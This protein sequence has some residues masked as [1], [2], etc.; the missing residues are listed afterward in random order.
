MISPPEECFI[1]D[2]AYVP[3]HLPGYVCAI[4]GAEPHLLGEDY[5]CFRMEDTL[6]F[7]GYPLRGSFAESA[8]GRAIETAVSRFKPRQVALIAPKI[9]EGVAAGQPR[10]RDQCYR[11]D[12]LRVPRDGKLR[13]MLRR[14]SRDTRVES[15]HDIREEH[16]A[17]IAE[18]LE[19]RPVSQ[20]IRYI[21][22]RIPA[23]VASV[24]TALVF[25]LRDRAEA[26]VAFDVAEFGAKEYAFYQFN[27]RSRKPYVPGASDLLLD[28]MIGA[29]RSEGKRFLNLGLGIHPGVQRFKEKWGGAPFL[30]YEYC[31]FASAP[32][33]L[34]DLILRR[35]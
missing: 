24:P 23:Y 35:L 4:S 33:N 20:Q 32:P 30:S 25:G 7:N 27:F 21:F 15:T 19:T 13:N 12:L 31:R 16:R 9:P 28:A 14:A 3:E 10:E 29:A 1:T 18:F 11:L 2:H 22:E 34:F 8:L 26:L 17:L 5:L 6:L